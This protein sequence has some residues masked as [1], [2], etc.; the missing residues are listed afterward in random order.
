[1]KKAIARVKGACLADDSRW[2]ALGGVRGSQEQVGGLLL[3]LEAQGRFF[4]RVPV[5]NR[6]P[7]R[8]E[9]F[10]NERS[11]ELMRARQP[12]VAVRVELRQRRRVIRHSVERRATD[13][14]R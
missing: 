3:H 2:G 7:W 12:H 4:K 10:V 8:R 14:P 6:F 13:E 5:E 11:L 1:M 9:D